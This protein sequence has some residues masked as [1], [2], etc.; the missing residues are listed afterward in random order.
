MTTKMISQR[1]SVS[2]ISIN[3]SNAQVHTVLRVGTLGSF[4]TQP[5][6]HIFYSTVN[7]S[8]KNVKL[9]LVF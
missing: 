3:S 2:S 8:K 6:T 4:F 1:R 9:I 7:M 5:Q